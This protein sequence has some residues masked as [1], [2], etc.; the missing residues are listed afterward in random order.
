M[1]VYFPGTADGRELHVKTIGEG[2]HNE[3]Q[4]KLL[5]DEVHSCY[6][7]V[8]TKNGK[9]I[10]RVST[11]EGNILHMVCKLLDKVPVDPSFIKLN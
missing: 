8:L 5:Q 1:S 10:S 11:E 7:M 3:T 9:E 6:T 2:A 4:L